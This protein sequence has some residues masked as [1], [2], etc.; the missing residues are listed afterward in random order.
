MIARLPSRTRR[1]PSTLD[2]R[3]LGAECGILAGL[4]MVPPSFPVSGGLVGIVGMPVGALVGAVF[5]PA[6]AYSRSDTPILLAAGT[7]FVLG[8]GLFGLWAALAH[9]A[10]DS[11]QL[12]ASLAVEYTV[13]VMLGLGYV[14]APFT[15]TGTFIGT[16][17]LRRLVSAA[18]GFRLSAS[19]LIAFVTL[20][21]ALVLAQA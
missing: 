2:L 17:L 1:S 11:P 7:A 4:A 5:A 6:I 18:P 19:L 20:L 16:M 21:T 3:L 8:S 14:T 10:A 13:A 9:P 15:A 12:I